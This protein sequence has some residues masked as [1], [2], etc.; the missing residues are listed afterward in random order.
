MPDSTVYPNIVFISGVSL[1]DTAI[2]IHRK[3]R[4]KCMNRVIEVDG[5]GI[6]KEQ[7][8]GGFQDEFILPISHWIESSLTGVPKYFLLVFIG[9]W[10]VTCKTT[11]PSIPYQGRTKS[12]CTSTN[13]LP[14]DLTFSMKRRQVRL[15]TPA[16]YCAW[17][18]WYL[19]DPRM[20][21]ARGPT[22][23]LVSVHLCL[24]LSEQMIEYRWSFTLASAPEWMSPLRPALL[25]SCSHLWYVLIFGKYGPFQLNSC[26]IGIVCFSSIWFSLKFSIL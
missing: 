19:Q 7:R 5:N 18:L 21:L 13:T 4:E 11:T 25:S 23:A 1:R 6:F 17:G 14:F 15:T 24:F 2:A 16:E 22:A 3:K 9:Q 20:I 10:S 8:K 26:V 12:K